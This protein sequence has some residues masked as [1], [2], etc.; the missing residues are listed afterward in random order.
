MRQGVTFK[1]ALALSVLCASGAPAEAQGKGFTPADMQRLLTVSD[2]SFHPDGQ[3]LVYSVGEVDKVKDEEVSD[4]WTVALK[5]SAPKRLTRTGHNEWQ[6][7]FSPDGKTVFFL[8]DAGKQETTQV[9]SMPLSGAG[10]KAVTAFA[11]GVEDYA[12]SPDG[13]KL[14]VIV[15]DAARAS[16][17]WMSAV[18][19]CIW[20]MSPTAVPRS[21]PVAR[22]ISTCLRFRRTARAS[23]SS[24]NAAMTRIGT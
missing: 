17:T 15:K 4:L 24:P 19:T 2:P 12:L 20:S 22:T 6:A 5:G 3:S 10:A 1:M 7:R 11:Q 16:G 18:C 9:W 14:A 23:R 13:A 21:S 8:S